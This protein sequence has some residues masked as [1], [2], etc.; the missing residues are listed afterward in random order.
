MEVLDVPVRPN[1]RHRL[2]CRFVVAVGAGVRV[3]RGPC[4][5][6]P[7]RPRP[8]GV[9]L[10]GPPGALL[11]GRFVR[12][13]L[14]PLP[15]LLAL[16]RRLREPVVG[17]LEVQLPVLDGPEPGSTFRHRDGRVGGGLLGAV[18]A[19]AAQVRS[20]FGTL[21]AAEVVTDE[22]ELGPVVEVRFLCLAVF[23]QASRRQRGPPGV[24]PVAREVER[25]REQPLDVVVVTL[26]EVLD[27]VEHLAHPRVDRRAVE[28]IDGR[29]RPPQE[30][31]VRRV[32][33]LEVDLDGSAR[34]RVVVLD[35]VVLVR[36]R[37]VEPVP[38]RRRVRPVDRR[39][40]DRLLR[41]I[42]HVDVL[43]VV[44]LLV[45]R[46]LVGRRRVRVRVRREELVRALDVERV[47]LQAES[48]APA[49]VGLNRREPRH[50][51]EQRVLERVA[52]R[53]PELVVL[54]D[55]RR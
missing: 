43:D 44:F 46:H 52:V 33:P 6:G 24:E 19:V 10:A 2:R 9:P 36:N 42:G 54:G 28:P 51:L 48:D 38:H 55:V 30:R 12:R 27:R 23:E 8:V 16:R 17:R 49:D 25:L 31:G 18:T 40:G 45:V 13:P 41:V 35:D 7:V 1:V 4:V 37:V 20:R 3:G 50:L 11:V 34:P 5:L 32:V 47:P 53:L 22:L 29:A 15:A 14:A 21:A 26:R 39:V